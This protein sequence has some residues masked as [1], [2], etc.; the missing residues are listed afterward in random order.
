[1]DI[2]SGNGIATT[3][4]A[5]TGKWRACHGVEYDADRHETALLWKADYDNSSSQ[6][7]DK[8]IGSATITP[9]DF[10]CGDMLQ[11][12]DFA[13]A[14]VVFANSPTWDAALVGSIGTVLDQQLAANTLVVSISRR[15]P[16]PSLD[17]VDLLK[18]PCNNGEFTF[19]ICRK[20]Q[21]D[22]DDD[23]KEMSLAMS[24]SSA[25]RSLRQAEGGS[26]LME[27]IDCSLSLDGNDGM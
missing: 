10:T 17:L 12:P 21:A 8:S 6:H 26:L 7:Q 1:M 13:T 9:L 25:I 18:M 27:L 19:Y 11:Y 23:G 16:S 15:F 2:G 5:M 24:D 22:G 4:A 20:T 14:S 3:A